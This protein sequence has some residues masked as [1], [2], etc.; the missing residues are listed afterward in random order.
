MKIHI[1]ALAALLVGSINLGA[2]DGAHHINGPV[3]IAG[4]T[5]TGDVST[6]NGPVAI[7]AKA[8]VAGVH[9]VNGG[10]SLGED[11]RASSMKT[12]NG[13]ISLAERAEVTGDIETVNGALTLA[14]GSKVGGELVNINGGIS[15]DG[16]RVG[17]GLRTVNA[18][19]KLDHGATIDG[20]ILMKKPKGTF[21]LSDSR[22]PRVVIGRD[23]TVNGT[24]KFEREVRLYVSDKAAHVGT[25]EGA[26]PVTYQGDNPPE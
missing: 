20:G 3:S 14:P 23:V 4:G 19:I 11:A 5:E 1:V 25:I 22:P 9:S 26:T 8:H 12:V 24:L 21:V 15:V 17:G 18:S 7:G 16:A 2:C 13:S 10:L 6:V